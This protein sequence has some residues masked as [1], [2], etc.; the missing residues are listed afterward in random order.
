MPTLFGMGRL[1]DEMTFHPNLSH[2]LQFPNTAIGLQAIVLFANLDSLMQT[3]LRFFQQCCWAAA[4]SSDYFVH[5]IV[6]PAPKS[7]YVILQP[8]L[9]PE[10]LLDCMQDNL[11][12]SDAR[13]YLL[14][15][16]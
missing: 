13:E 11:S 12:K 10:A 2:L 15:A 4:F 14:F 3:D 16:L 9:F 7:G 8:A 5:L 1:F 6:I